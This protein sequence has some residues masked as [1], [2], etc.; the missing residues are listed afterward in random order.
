[1]LKN[2]NT[3]IMYLVI[4][5]MPVLRRRNA[6]DSNQLQGDPSHQDLGWVQPNGLTK[7][8]GVA[9]VGGPL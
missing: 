5:S 6:I 1:M 8:C 4:I 7:I 9:P 2:L 3:D